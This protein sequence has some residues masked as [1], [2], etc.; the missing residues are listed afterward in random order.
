MKKIQSCVCV[1]GCDVVTNVP[2]EFLKCIWGMNTV[3]VSE[4]NLQTLLPV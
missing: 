1:L 3:R 2:A 4:L